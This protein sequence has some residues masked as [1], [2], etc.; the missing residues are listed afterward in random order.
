MP[1]QVMRASAPAVFTMRTFIRKLT[2]NAH[3]PV[4]KFIFRLDVYKRQTD[5]IHSMRQ[6]GNDHGQGHGN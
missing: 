3:Q 4:D 1:G 2:D 6:H 5:V